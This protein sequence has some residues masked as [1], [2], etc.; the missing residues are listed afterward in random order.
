M[1]DDT[2]SPVDAGREDAIA[3]LD[4]DISAEDRRDVVERIEAVMRENRIQ[5]TPAMLA[6]QSGRSGAAFP[7]LVNVVALV[8]LVG[9]LTTGYLAFRRSEANLSGAHGTFKTAEGRVIAELRRQADEQLQ[10]KDDEIRSI[11]ERLTGVRQERDKILSEIDERVRQ[12]EGELRR[13]LA[14]E[15]DG[16]RQKLLAA[17]QSRE[18]VD[19]RITDLQTR[20]GDEIAREIANYRKQLDQEWERRLAGLTEVQAQFQQALAGLEQERLSISREAQARE[21]ALRR[22]AAEQSRAREELAARTDEA[23]REAAAARGA[24]EALSEQSRQE[25]LVRSQILGLYGR[26]ADDV[27]AARFEA[28]NA[29]L[30]SLRGLY[31]DPKFLGLP[32]VQERMRVDLFLADSLGRLIKQQQQERQIDFA[33]L[34]SADRAV[35]ALESGARE[36]KALADAGRFDDA[37][38]RYREALSAVPTAAEAYALL[39]KRQDEGDASRLAEFRARRAEADAALG[40]GAYAAALGQYAAALAAF[41][42]DGVPGQ[43]G[44]EAAE[45]VSR[46]GDR[47][48]LAAAQAA[49]APAPSAAGPAAPLPSPQ[50]AEAL[51]GADRLLAARETQRAFDAYL[52]VARA[53]PGSTQLP[54]ALAGADRAMRQMAQDAQRQA[55]ELRGTVAQLQ[56][57]VA[58]QQTEV[59]RL[60]PFEARERSL[61]QRYESYAAEEDRVVRAQGEAGLAATKLALDSFLTTEPAAT[62]L[63]G[64]KNRTQRYHDAFER[65]GRQNAIGEAAD[66]VYNLAGAR[67]RAARMAFLDG[68]ARRSAGDP[69]TLQLIEELRA[70]VE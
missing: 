47:L 55:T 39:L 45:A 64:L 54:E 8:A 10:A 15:M 44:A 70:L 25:A 21:Q 7:L 62:L 48:A 49:G 16:E 36:A 24:L 57:Q 5:V 68:E 51:R 4:A 41:A 29:R 30:E 6:V 34:A 12:K 46:T 2:N 61:R 63:P 13:A 18:Q 42:G 11:Q 3:E 33:A 52:A 65:A 38:L 37:A 59:R 53:Y 23:L 58:G 67:D 43:E 22:E 9:G 27:N 20:R 14:A 40:R 35:R 19:A 17:G 28:A 26:I 56:G 50:A 31:A 32:G 69:G 1:S 60:A 66:I